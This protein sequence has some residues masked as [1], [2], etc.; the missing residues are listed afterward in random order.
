MNSMN[1]P[2]WRLFLAF[3]YTLALAAVSALSFG[4]LS[5]VDSTEGTRCTPLHQQSCACDGALG[6][7]SC[8]V[9]GSGWD[10]CVCTPDPVESGRFSTERILLLD[11]D[12]DSYCG[13]RL[14]LTIQE[15]RSAIGDD[16]IASLCSCLADVQVSAGL[17][18]CANVESDSAQF[19]ADCVQSADT[20][21]TPTEC[22][23]PLALVEQCEVT[24][25]LYIGTDCSSALP[26]LAPC[27]ELRALPGCDNF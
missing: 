1:Q 6:T 5:C 13:S 17:F 14:T 18:D 12:A 2:L 20:L 15:A 3:P 22:T 16:D 11:G 10:T 8:R 25:A 19:A 21:Q 27:E 7:Q 9:D 23:A 4:A 26:R 24:V